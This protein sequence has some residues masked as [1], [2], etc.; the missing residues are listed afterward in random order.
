MDMPKSV[1]SRRPWG[2]RGSGQHTFI[3]PCWLAL[4]FEIWKA[5]VNI[6]GFEHP[7]FLNMIIKKNVHSL[8]VCVCSCVSDCAPDSNRNGPWVMNMVVKEG[9]CLRRPCWDEA[10]SLADLL[11]QCKLSQYQEAD[12]PLFPTRCKALCLMPRA[13]INVWTFPFGLLQ[14]A[15]GSRCVSLVR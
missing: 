8:C 3:G 15:T 1:L 10:L 9:L 5:E 12:G 14:S 2:Q 6:L 11:G 7:T 4:I 13:A